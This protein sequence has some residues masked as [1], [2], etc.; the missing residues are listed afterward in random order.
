MSQDEQMEKYSKYY[1][2]TLQQSSWQQF[3]LNVMEQPKAQEPLQ[4][5]PGMGVGSLNNEISFPEGYNEEGSYMYKKQK[6]RSKK[7]T[8]GRIFDCP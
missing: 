7:D 3:M 4:I 2:Q 5:M 1:G 6:R 8:D